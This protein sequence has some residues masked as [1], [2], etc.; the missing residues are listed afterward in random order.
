MEVICHGTENTALRGRRAQLTREGLVR[1]RQNLSFVISPLKSPPLRGQ[2][3]VPRVRLHDYRSL[4]ADSPQCREWSC[5]HACFM[6][7]LGVDAM[8]QL[9]TGSDGIAVENA[10]RLDRATG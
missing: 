8:S 2:G 6:A 10:G 3:F 7:L 4:Y 5:G 1:L 9:S